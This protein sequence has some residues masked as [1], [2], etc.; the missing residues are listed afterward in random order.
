VK[1]PEQYILRRFVAADLNA[2]SYQ[3]GFLQLLLL[4]SIAG[5]GKAVLRDAV[6]FVQK[7]TRTFG[8]LGQSSPRTD[9]MV[10]RVVG[11]IASLSFAAE[12]MIEAV[13][14]A[15]EELYQGALA[16]TADKAQYMA[17]D[18]KA[19]EAQQMVIDLVLQATTLLFE[20]GGAS[21]TSETRQL[22][23]HWRNARTLASHTPAIYRERVIGDYHLNGAMPDNPWKDVLQK[24]EAEKAGE[25]GGTDGADPGKR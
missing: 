22:D 6:A 9:P 13:A 3:K 4:A 25:A 16:G 12:S 24:A 8:V 10:Q 17:A 21:A 23:R 15:F 11:R 20:V 1:I 7:R 5:V 19:F 2:N 14:G 18:V